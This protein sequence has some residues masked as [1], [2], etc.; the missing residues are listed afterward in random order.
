MSK[1]TLGIEKVLFQ[2]IKVW[3]NVAAE[4]MENAKALEGR[5]RYCEMGGRD[6]LRHI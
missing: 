5:S 1:E 2:Q 3:W 6:H 4:E